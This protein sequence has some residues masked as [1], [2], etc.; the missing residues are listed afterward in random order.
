M[1]ATKLANPNDNLLN[2]VV[3]PQG[4]VLGL[5]LFL[6]FVNDKPKYVFTDNSRPRDRNFS[7]KPRVILRNWFNCIIKSL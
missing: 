6:I 5:L 1:F 2:V 7:V 3:D 4:S